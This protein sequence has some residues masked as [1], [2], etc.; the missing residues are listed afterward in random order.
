MDIP[1]SRAPVSDNSTSISRFVATGMKRE[2]LFT[3]SVSGPVSEKNDNT[4]ADC[5]K[6]GIITAQ[7]CVDECQSFKDRIGG[8]AKC[9]IRAAQMGEKFLASDDRRFV[10][11]MRCERRFAIR[12]PL[13]P[14]T[15]KRLRSAVFPPHFVGEP[16]LGGD[17][18][19]RPTAQDHWNPRPKHLSIAFG[20]CEILSRYSFP[21]IVSA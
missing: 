7:H 5:F 10:K 20:W 8:N 1:A 19:L 16:Y 21:A 18:L 9:S 15:I 4:V 14:A 13:D 12:I 3:S 17:G 2:D 6:F 11:N